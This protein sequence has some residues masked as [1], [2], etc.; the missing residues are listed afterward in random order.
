MIAFD[1]TI[2]LPLLY[3]DVSVPRDA[4]GKP[5][6]KAKERL[7]FLVA[8]ISKQGDKIV[9]PTPALSEILVHAGDAMTD[10][11]NILHK[12]TCFRIA[13]FDERAAIEVALLASEDRTKKKK[14]A[15][16][17]HA[18]T[19]AKVKYDHQIAAIAKV[20]GADTLYTDD[21][22]QAKIAQRLGLKVIKISEL[23]LPPEDKQMSLALDAPD[24][25]Q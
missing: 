16:K 10:Y 12:K 11:L 7:Q 18:E 17:N 5:I 1:A 22:N 24:I 20:E 9:I 19:V 15:V 4:S 6:E 3:P 21:K 2:L 25:K 14:T 13:D 23:P 8:Q